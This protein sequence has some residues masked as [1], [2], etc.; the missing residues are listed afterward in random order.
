M[1]IDQVQAT[2][3]GLYECVV[4]GDNGDKIGTAC[5]LSHDACQRM[6]G[7]SF[8]KHPNSGIERLP[9]KRLPGDGFF[10]GTDQVCK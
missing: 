3:A 8:M 2:D 6:R 1:I 4:T 9:N 7:K 10:A 5:T